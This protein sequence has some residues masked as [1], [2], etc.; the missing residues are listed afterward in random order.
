MTPET[1]GNLVL[2]LLG[3]GFFALIAFVVWC[4]ERCEHLWERQEEIPCFKEGNGSEDPDT[5]RQV[6]R[7]K[8]CGEIKTV[9]LV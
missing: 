6:L 7:C 2:L 3:L 9:K 1:V 8:H 5:I 4:I